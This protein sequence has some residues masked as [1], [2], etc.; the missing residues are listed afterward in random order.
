MRDLGDGTDAGAVPGHHV[1]A[2]ELVVVELLGVVRQFLRIDLGDQQGVAQRLGG[3]AVGHADEAQQQ[4][5]AVHP[6]V[7]HGERAGLRW[8]RGQDGAGRQPHLRFVGADLDGDLTLD[9]MGTADAR[10]D[11]L[12]CAFRFPLHP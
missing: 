4:P 10:D 6:A 5:T 3:G 2:D 1:E 11:E 7:G 12:H 9:A 8:V